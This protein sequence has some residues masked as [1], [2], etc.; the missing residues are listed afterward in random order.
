MKL[1]VA[2]YGKLH[3]DVM[4]LGSHHHESRQNMKKKKLYHQD[5]HEASAYHPLYPLMSLSTLSRPSQ[6][7]K[8]TLRNNGYEKGIK[9]VF[10]VT[11]ILNPFL[12]IL[13]TDIL[14]AIYL[15][16]YVRVL[17][18]D[19]IPFRWYKKLNFLSIL[20]FPPYVF[21]IFTFMYS[22]AYCM[23]KKHH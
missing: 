14:F 5:L 20:L 19:K 22:Y 9:K 15:L 8:Y 11:E 6:F 4:S 10:Q 2:Q 16:A 1:Q 18:V 3:C 13:K 12:S 17:H 21:I 7:L 23:N